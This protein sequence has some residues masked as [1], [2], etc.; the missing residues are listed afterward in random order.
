MILKIHPFSRESS[1]LAQNGWFLVKR[2]HLNFSCRIITYSYAQ[3]MNH[4]ISGD[5]W[6]SS[7]LP[8]FVWFGLIRLN[9][10]KTDV[11]TRIVFSQRYVRSGRFSVVM[12]P[13]NIKHITHNDLLLYLLIIT[14]LMNYCMTQLID[15]IMV[16]YF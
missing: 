5:S 10:E 8:R 2:M 11:F 3:R 12:K 9:L 4:G 6:K 15:I 16:V 1:F 7:I 13:S 14:T